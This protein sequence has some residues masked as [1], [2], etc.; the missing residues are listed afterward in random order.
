MEETVLV[1]VDAGIARITLN[2]PEA[3]NA[4]DSR[5][6]SELTG[7]V[8]SA[9]SDPSVR[10]LILRGAGDKAFCAGADIKEFTPPASL[11]DAREER[12]GPKWTDAIAACPKP[13]VAA[14]HGYC[15]G[16]GLEIALACDIR[17]A[18]G[19]AV[20]GLPE[21]RRAILP[22]AGGTQRLPRVVGLGPALRMIL[23]GEHIGAAEA[24]RIGLVGEVVPNGDLDAA[25]DR[26]ADAL[27]RTGPRAVAYAKEAV[28]RGLELP[29]SE[30]LRLE[31]EL[32][33]LLTTTQDRAEGAAAFKERRDP[34]YTG[35]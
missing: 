13:T 31:G 7:A 22:G 33:A 12:T 28:M 6:R 9:G 2:R 4:I 27:R 5:M 8:H 34:V 30:G 26:L 25:A 20:F 3:R 18:T 1:D 23:T 15:L 17:I 32:S 29:L 11:V 21:V 35:Q 16:G 24:L 14:V 10:G 19:D